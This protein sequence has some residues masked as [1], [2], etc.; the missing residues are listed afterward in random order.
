MQTINVWV[1]GCFDILHIGHIKL[2]EYAKSHGTH[3]VVGIDSDER[4][5]EAK[6]SSR[7]F[8]SLEDRKDFLESIRVVD[9]V[10]AYSTDQQLEEHLTR[11]NISVMVIGSDWKGKKIVGDHLVKEIIFFDRIGNH[12]TTRILKNEICI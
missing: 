11:N 4:I 9:K 5:K 8:N 10:V 12:S 1:N 6:G 7:P 2:L 3:L